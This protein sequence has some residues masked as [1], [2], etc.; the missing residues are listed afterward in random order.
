[1]MDEQY[2]MAIKVLR[3]ADQDFP[4]SVHVLNLLG[5]AY[6]NTGQQKKASGWLLISVVVVL[7]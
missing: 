4:D 6:N 7:N 2:L 1:M 3:K 5:R